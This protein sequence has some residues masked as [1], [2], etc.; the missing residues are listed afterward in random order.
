MSSE[1]TLPEVFRVERERQVAQVIVEPFHNN[2]VQSVSRSIIIEE[3]EES[4]PR[5]NPTDRNRLITGP[6]T[7][8]IQLIIQPRTREMTMSVSKK[9]TSLHP[10][11]ISTK[12]QVVQ[13]GIEGI[14]SEGGRL[15]ISER[16][17]SREKKKESR[18]L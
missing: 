15:A 7:R 16:S 11:E 17:R 8:V 18:G 10:P 6:R 5:V 3:R 14:T 12:K 9:M 13:R 4:G 2:E 1:E